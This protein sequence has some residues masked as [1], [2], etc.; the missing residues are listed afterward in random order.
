MRRI[1]IIT[2][3]TISFGL[4]AFDR[5]DSLYYHFSIGAGISYGPENVV[6][7]I[8]PKISLYYYHP[9]KKYQKYAKIEKFEEPVVKQTPKINIFNLADAF[10]NKDKMGAW[11]IYRQAI[12]LGVSPEEICGVLFWKVKNM[13]MNNAKNFSKIELQNL[14]SK[15]TDIYHNSHSGNID[16]TIA[17]EEF[18]LSSLNKK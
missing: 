14:S 5:T 13:M 8:P 6:S 9:E 1:L 15:L 12:S 4:K 11:V 7:S 16:F 3:L 2:F 18:I 17:L 10:S